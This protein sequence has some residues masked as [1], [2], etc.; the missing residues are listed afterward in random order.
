MKILMVV[1]RRLVAVVVGLALVW[2]VVPTGRAVADPTSPADS[3]SPSQGDLVRPD[4]VSA[5]VTARA[6]GQRVEVLS[7]R[8]E[9]G[10][11]W[12][13]PDGVVDQEVSAG[14]V[15]FEDAAAEGGWRRIDTRLVRGADGRLRANAV[16]DAVMVGTTPAA[17]VVSVEGGVG[18]SLPGVQLPV[19]TVE[20]STA[21]YA[22]VVPGVD[23]TVEVLPAGFELL[24]VVKSKAGAAELVSRFGKAGQVVLP[25]TVTTDGGVSTSVDAAGGLVVTNAKGARV[26]RFGSPVMW[27][28]PDTSAGKGPAVGD[29]GVGDRG[30]VEPVVFKPAAATLRGGKASRRV[31]VVASVAWLT[32]AE[33]RF[34]VTID[35]T[36]ASDYRAP[37]FDT[38][39][40]QGFTTD[41]SADGEL[42]LGNNGSGQVARTYFNWDNTLFKGRTIV[43]ASLSMFEKH[44]WSCE[45]RAWSAYDAGLSSTASR[46]T[47]Q[48]SV[49]SKRATSTQTKGASTACPA[50]RVSMYNLT[51]LAQAWSATTAAQVGMMLRAD[52]ETDPYGWKRFYSADSNYQPLLSVSYNRVSGS[53]ATPGLTGPNY[54]GGAVDIEDT[55]GVGGGA[56]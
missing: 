35:P 37:A 40:Q 19:P 47:V 24:W 52:D 14:P 17:A 48:P 43:S 5:T 3:P 33:R 8:T 15:Q 1:L 18:L 30:V 34:P 32:G 42:K 20:G 50:G 55:D 9:F 39:V 53:P 38:F 31:D 41:Q 51:G 22:E 27:D 28:A 36:Y 4:W 54:R 7:E 23:V 44:S 46:W 16:K 56:E 26:G 21:V 11:T 13:R 49:G 10:S 25:T 6:T 45:E 29:R 2:S 12:V